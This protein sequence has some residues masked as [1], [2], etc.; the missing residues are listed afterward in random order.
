MKPPVAHL[1]PPDRADLIRSGRREGMRFVLEQAAWASLAGDTPQRA[2]QVPLLGLWGDRSG[3]VH[4][5][6]HD[7]RARPLIASVAVEAGR[8]YALSATMPAAIPFERMVRDLWGFEAMHARDL[9]CLLD[10]GSWEA[11][12][13]MAVRPGPAPRSAEPP[14]WRAPPGGEEGLAYVERG[15]VGLPDALGARMRASVDGER[16]RVVELQHG[17]GHRG[18]LERILGA[19]P[20]GAARVAERVS[21]TAMVANGVAFARAVEAA[22]GTVISSRA[23]LLR[24]A[25]GEVERAASFLGCLAGCA[26]AA[27]ARRL[28]AECEILLERVRVAAGIGFGHR[29]GAGFVVPGGVAR[30][31]DDERVEALRGLAALIERELRPLARL[32]EASDG[33][34]RRLA[35]LAVVAPADA[36]LRVAS[37]VVGRASGQRFDARR[38]ASSVP[39]EAPAGES[40]DADARMRL[41]LAGLGQAGQRLALV[42]D[43]LGGGAVR[44]PLGAVMGEGL[45]VAE[46][47]EGDV[48]HFV[49]LDADGTV[50]AWFVREPALGHL[51]LFEGAC[52]GALVEDLGAA[53]W[54]FGVSG[55]AVDL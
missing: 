19:T 16:V 20:E 49:R 11:T 47:P 23:S 30:D 35:G 17:Y 34:A 15:P 43:G 52:G 7:G 8:Y 24:E 39:V 51:G 54:S 26:R 32:Y 41:R 21:A 45:G 46:A 55:E 14:E 3:F 28:A 1:F 27:G 5:L 48:W 18:L 33:L 38:L 10:H 53:L 22:T 13:P 6:F 4:A 9:R 2:D 25:A 31:L 29:F 36:V 42:L 44:G 40:G 37:G 12:A 50:G